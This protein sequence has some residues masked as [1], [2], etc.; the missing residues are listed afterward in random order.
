VRLEQTFVFQTSCIPCPAS[1]ICVFVLGNFE[2]HHINLN[3]NSNENFVLRKIN[4]ISISK[5]QFNFEGIH[6]LIF[7]SVFAN[8][9][10]S[11]SVDSVWLRQ[12][13]DSLTSPNKPDGE[14]NYS[15]LLSDGSGYSIQDNS[16]PVVPL[17]SPVISSIQAAFF[18]QT[19][20]SASTKNLPI[21]LSCIRAR[22]RLWWRGYNACDCL[23]KRTLHRN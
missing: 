9:H 22:I 5:M 20:S 15:P 10:W 16:A 13:P 21:S 4:W 11:S 23:S 17:G 7:F 1:R 18:S 6:Y 2:L 19:C 8:V 12:C 3:F 14:R